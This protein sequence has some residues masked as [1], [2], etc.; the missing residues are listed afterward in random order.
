VYQGHLFVGSQ[1]L[2]DTGMRHHPLNPMTDANL[3]RVLQKQTS[4]PVKL[5]PLATVRGDLAAAFRTREPHLAI[6][7]AI[8]NDDLHTIGKASLQLPVISGGSGLGLGLPQAYREAGWWNN[9]PARPTMPQVKGFSA[10]LAGSC[11][12]ATRR[13]IQHARLRMPHWHLEQ[14]HKPRDILAWAEP[15]LANGPVL[16]ESSAT[17]DELRQLDDSAAVG[18]MIEEKHADIALGLVEH[19]VRRLVVAGGET[20]GAVVARLGVSALRIGP[21][22]A[23]GVPWTESLSSPALAL[24]LKSGNFGGD[25]FFTAALEM[26]P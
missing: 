4:L 16:I 5:I 22:I 12:D 13:Q 24:A 19:G 3:V 20:S 26:L 15:H 1:L 14:T 6:V 25:D 11:S 2:H 23:P 9:E 21:G 8:T 7:D 18:R 10:I 17:P